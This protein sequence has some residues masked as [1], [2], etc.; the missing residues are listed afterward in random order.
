MLSDIAISQ[1]YVLDQ[2]RAVDFYVGTLGLE[3]HTDVDLG[4]MRWLTVNVPGAP[5]REIV[6][7][8]PGGPMMDEATT[9]TVRELV[10]KGSAG[11]TL[12]FHTDDCQKTFEALRDAGVDIT[13]EPTKQD[14]GIDFGLR[15]PFGN[16]IRISQPLV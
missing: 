15:D 10:S 8:L 6:L 16:H 7:E 5:H 9:D 1:I 2:D 14:Y 11:G 3:I 13:Q 4:F 12:F